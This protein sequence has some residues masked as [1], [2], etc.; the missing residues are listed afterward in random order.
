MSKSI[1]KQTMPEHGSDEIPLAIPTVEA[2]KLLAHR[3]RSNWHD[4][5]FFLDLDGTLIALSAHP[6]SVEIPSYLAATLHC[7]EVKAQGALAI[8]TGRPVAFVDH[9]FP[10]HRFTVAGLHGAE[11]RYGASVEPRGEATKISA[12]NEIQPA[13]LSAAK[14]SVARDIAPN[15]RLHL[16]DKGAAFALHYRM[17]AECKDEAHR[18]MS[19]ALKLA[20]NGYQL[21][22]GKMVVEICPASADKAAALQH[23][24]QLT[25]FL[26]RRPFAAGDDLTDEPMFAAANT[27]SGAA[28]FVAAGDGTRRSVAG[29]AISDPTDFRYWLQEILS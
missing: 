28:M 16:E 19:E 15:P 25:P 26:G 23:L 1:I 8:V 2:N 21:K 7:L 5:A 4:W 10:K 9:I 17:A 14:A 20:P 27:A 3:I 22:F 29:F 13:A 11:L 24:M 18:I 12:A 6:E